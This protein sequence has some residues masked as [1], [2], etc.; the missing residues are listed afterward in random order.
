MTEILDFSFYFCYQYLRK[1]KSADPVNSA[2]TLMMIVLLCVQVACVSFAKRILH[3]PAFRIDT[4][5]FVLM[6]L[7]LQGFIFYGLFSYFIKT[8]RYKRLIKGRYKP[9][10]SHYVVDFLI[11]LFPCW[12][13]IGLSALLRYF[14]INF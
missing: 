5:I 12:L 14:R 13:L 10:N 4:F 9:I 3:L 7:I 1:V 2:L 11:I 8:K 6:G